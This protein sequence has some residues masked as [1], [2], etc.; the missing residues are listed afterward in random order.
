MFGRTVL[1]FVAGNLSIGEGN[2]CSYSLQNFRDKVAH[3]T[4]KAPT[5]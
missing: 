2:V 3:L 1:R 4:P 5:S